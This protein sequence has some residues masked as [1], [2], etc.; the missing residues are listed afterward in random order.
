MGKPPEK[1][2]ESDAY[3]FYMR[4]RVSFIL[5][6]GFV[7]TIQKKNS[8]LFLQNAYL[9]CSKMMDFKTKDYVGNLT[10]IELTLT[11]DDFIVF[12]QHY[13]IKKIE[14]LD[15]IEFM[16]ASELFDRYIEKFAK[17]KRE[18]KGAVRNLAKLF[19]NNLYG[20]MAK[21]TN[22]SF[23][24]VSDREFSLTGGLDFD[25]V[26]G[27]SKK[28]VNIAIGAA[29]TAKA[30]R[31]QIE[32]I[33]NNY[34][35]FVYSDTDS[36]HCIGR[37]EDFVGRI[38]DNEYGAYKIEAT[39]KRAKYVRQKTYIEEWDQDQID[40]DILELAA[41]CE[42]TGLDFNVESRRYFDEKE[43]INICAAGMTPEQ[44]KRFRIEYDFDDFRPG[45][46]ISGGKLKPVNV[47]GGVILTEVDFTIR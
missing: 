8:F 2:F 47:A 34:S 36:L 30:R 17:I 23:K 10:M 45:L 43:Y 25:I 12:Q 33:Q 40:R 31:Y 18:S 7:P 5:K 38:H 16:T 39:W 9:K 15:Y 26:Q 22:S 37:P 24:K 14:Y 42:K 35:R 1:L 29:I 3:Y 13:I 21:G 20:Q 4:I 44:K 6:D 41:R 11:K 32:T 46:T 28:V 27:N 19:Q